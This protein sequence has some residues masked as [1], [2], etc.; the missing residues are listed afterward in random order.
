MQDKLDAYSNSREVALPLHERQLL[1]STAAVK[2]AMASP[3]VTGIHVGAPGNSIGV[4][5][6]TLSTATTTSGCCNPD[7]TELVT[8]SLTTTG[9]GGV[10][11]SVFKT[12]FTS[13]SGGSSSGSKVKASH[14]IKAQTSRIVS[15]FK[16][17]AVVSSVV[18]EFSGHKD[19]VW[20]IAT[21]ARQSIIGTASADHTACIWSIESG[22]PLLQYTGHS[23]SVNSIKFHPQRDLVLTG[24]GDGTAHIWQA[25]VNWES[26]KYLLSTYKV[27]PIHIHGKLNRRF[28]LCFKE[29]RTFIRR[30]T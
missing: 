30:G 23:G 4:G 10:N 28:S 25:A 9:C 21:K 11:K 26:S 3:S 8:G 24:S 22:R 19:G 1:T 13:G 5:K 18:K 6:E 2:D 17:P 29:R 27:S 15:S 16:T 20:Q 7:E 14:K 12:K